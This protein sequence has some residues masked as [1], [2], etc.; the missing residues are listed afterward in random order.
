MKGFVVA[1]THSGV[2]KTS[3]ALGLM[4]AFS[5]RGLAVQPYKI[6]PDY[7]D[8]TYHRVVTGRPSR[9]LDGWLTGRA[10]V[11][12]SLGRGSGDLAIVEGVMGVFDG[13]HPRTENGSTAEIAKWLGAPIILVLDAGGMA[14]S[15][16]AVALGFASFDPA[17]PLLGVVFN[18]IGGARHLEILTEAVAP[19][20]IP[21]LGGLPK[22]PDLGLDGRHLG[23]V[24]ATPSSLPP[25]KVALLADW[26]E[27]GIDIQRLL[28][29]AAEL[30]TPAAGRP[31]PRPGCCRIAYALDDAFHFYYMENLERLEEAG[32]EL[33]PFSP[34]RDSHLP[35]ADGIL[36]GGGYPEVHAAE[37]S[38]NRS[39]LG[40]LRGFPGPIYGECGGLMAL[41]DAIVTDAGEFPMAGALAGQA[42][43]RTRLQALGYAEVRLRHDGDWGPAG[44]VFRGHRFH[45][46][47]ATGIPDELDR[48][49]EVRSL[50]GDPVTEGYRRGRTLGSYVHAHWGSNPALPVAFVDACSRWAA[51]RRDGVPTAGGKQ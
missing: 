42:R 45:Y 35:E 48:L 38:A 4:A 9:N 39:L 33:V 46:S 43:M 15:A 6:G 29:R 27:A 3:V 51:E 14:R 37:L 28:A 34:L 12:D 5:R 18:R 25:P 7:L 24:T 32:A 17:M 49:Y 22:R 30:A 8:P 19:T 21:V 26:V 1:G 44:T 20:G 40:E 47:E 31:S 23:L 11:L 16:A 2:G 13:A 10:G 41:M 50:R 36:L